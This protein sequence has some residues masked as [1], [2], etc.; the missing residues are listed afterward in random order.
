MVDNLI[1]QSE[2]LINSAETLNNIYTKYPRLKKFIQID[3]I[4]FSPE[5]YK[6]GEQLELEAMK[7]ENY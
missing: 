4:V 2:E 3:D 6:E 1:Q 5:K 7:N